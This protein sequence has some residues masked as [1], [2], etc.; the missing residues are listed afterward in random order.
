MMMFDDRRV[1]TLN[2]IH[3]LKIVLCSDLFGLLFIV[4]K[5][6]KLPLIIVVKKRLFDRVTNKSS[7]AKKFKNNDKAIHTN[8][9]THKSS[10]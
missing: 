1:N 6:A 5:F 4:F 3:T 8:H 9:A 7:L 10:M 2:Y